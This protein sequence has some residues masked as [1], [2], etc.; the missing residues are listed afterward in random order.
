MTQAESLQFVTQLRST[1]SELE[2][3]CTLL[4]FVSIPFQCLH[5][6]YDRST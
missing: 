4:S 3:R 2:V 6:L 5:I 1:F